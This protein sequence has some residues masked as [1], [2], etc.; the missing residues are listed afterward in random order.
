MTGISLQQ[1]HPCVTSSDNAM[2]LACCSLLPLPEYQLRNCLQ[3]GVVHSSCT[4]LW[5]C[6]CSETQH[7]YTCKHSHVINGRLAWKGA[8]IESRCQWVNDD[9]HLGDHCVKLV[10]AFISFT[11]KVSLRNWGLVFIIFYRVIPC[12]YVILL[13]TSNSDLD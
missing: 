9:L 6:L 11:H 8:W 2:F 5:M 12:T 1:S 10:D 7:V 3:L 4:V 13:V